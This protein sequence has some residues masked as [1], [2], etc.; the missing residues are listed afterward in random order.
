[1]PNQRLIWNNDDRLSWRR[2]LSWGIF[3]LARSQ[4]QEAGAVPR[5]AIAIV[6]TTRGA[7]GALA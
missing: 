7:I 6:P 2:Y 4:Q 1:M 5:A 3:A